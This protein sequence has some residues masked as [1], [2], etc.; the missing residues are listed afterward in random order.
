MKKIGIFFGS[1]T[2]NTESAAELLIEKF[3]AENADLFN[4]SDASQEDLENYDNLIFGTS[5]WGSGELQ[6]DF[7]E[8]LETVES[9]ELSG[10]VVAIFGYG[11]QDSYADTFV[12]GMGTIYSAIK[13]KGCNLVGYTATEGYEFSES[14]AVEDGRFVG[15]VLDEENQSDLTGERVE[16]WIEELKKELK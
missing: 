5:T 12:D 16:N 13:D 4:V 9:A 10:K 11:D 3:G 8:F 7:D 6:D 14:T 15:L 1:T 2:G